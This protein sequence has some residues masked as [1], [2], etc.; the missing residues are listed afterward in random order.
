MKKI[1]LIASYPKNSNT[2]MRSLLSSLIF[3]KDGKFNFKLLEKIKQFDTNKQY[4]FA[5]K[6]D[7]HDHSN[8][9]DIKV[10]SKYWK[11]AQKRINEF[12]SFQ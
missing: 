3:T 4:H 11:M 7:R 10:V 6:I 2:Y 9:N 5:H 12:S 1:L 8:L